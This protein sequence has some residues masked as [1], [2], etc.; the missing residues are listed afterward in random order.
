VLESLWE[1]K[2]DVALVL[3]ALALT[4]Y[5]EMVLGVVGLQGAARLGGAS[6]ATSRAAGWQRTIRGI[7]LSLDD[8]AQVVRATV[9]RR[10]GGTAA[11][12]VAGVAADATPR[13]NWGSWGERYTPGSRIAIG[14]GVACAL[15][16][17]AAP[18]LTHHTA[19]SALAALAADLRPLP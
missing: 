3:F 15:L 19:A 17:V 13:S 6:R 10:R 9:M 4:L 18:W 14:L 16:I 2:L 7:L 8:G 11:A 12:A 1:L 5:M